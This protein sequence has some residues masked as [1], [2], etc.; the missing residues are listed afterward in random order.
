[1]DDDIVIPFI[2]GL[3]VELGLKRISGQKKFY[4]VHDKN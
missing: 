3:D 2:E 1:M 4:F